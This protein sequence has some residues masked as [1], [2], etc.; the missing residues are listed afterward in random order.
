[1]YN[2]ARRLVFRCKFFEGKRGEVGDDVELDVHLSA[3]SVTSPY[4]GFPP[5]FSEC[6]VN[7]ALRE[8]VSKLI[9]LIH[10]GA[11]NNREKR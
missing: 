10:G 3:A 11:I 5:G 7:N 4:S 1:L 9:L 6:E 2:F 8:E